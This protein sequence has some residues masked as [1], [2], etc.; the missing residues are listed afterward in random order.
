MSGLP[1]EMWFG[2]VVGQWP[3]HCWESEG[4]AMAWLASAGVDERRRLWK[5][6]V[7]DPVEFE[8]VNPKPYLKRKVADASHAGGAS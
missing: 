4:H 1:E 3:V 8:A 7:V 2:N 6:K 5:A